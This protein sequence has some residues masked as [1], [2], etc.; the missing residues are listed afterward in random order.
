M[1]QLGRRMSG[2]SEMRQPAFPAV[3]LP[4]TNPKPM[5]QFPKPA[6]N[7]LQQ[8]QQQSS[9]ALQKQKSNEAVNGF[10]AKLTGS[11]RPSAVESIEITS[12]HTT[13]P[14]YTP[15]EWSCAGEAEDTDWF[16]PAEVVSFGFC[17]QAS[18]CP[19][20][21]FLNCIPLS[22]LPYGHPR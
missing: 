1:P 7:K 16:K 10:F 14:L 19:G 21:P 9:N 6:R 2:Q 20:R 17:A 18:D 22:P 8:I 13:A 11:R 15:L 12:L 3:L 4:V 5:H